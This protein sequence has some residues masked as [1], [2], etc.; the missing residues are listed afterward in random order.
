MLLATLAFFSSLLGF[1]G[2]HQ[3]GAMDA[4]GFEDPTLGWGGVPQVSGVR[5]TTVQ[6]GSRSF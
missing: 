5:L 1:Q 4:P 6:S 3:P 2:G